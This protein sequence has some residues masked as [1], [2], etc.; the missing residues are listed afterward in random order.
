MTVVI[1]T[2]EFEIPKCLHF[3]SGGGE[4]DKANCKY[5]SDYLYIMGLILSVVSQIFL[6]ISPYPPLVFS[7]NFRVLFSA[8]PLVSFSVPPPC[9]RLKSIMEQ[10]FYFS[11]QQIISNLSVLQKEY[12][13]LCYISTDIP[14]IQSWI[15]ILIMLKKPCQE[16]H[17]IL[18]NI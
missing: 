17:Q 15:S 14:T 13:V 2:S 16:V 8:P 4:G 18:R 9:V 11:M 1:L 3:L 10:V 6:S 5:L 12:S 7:H